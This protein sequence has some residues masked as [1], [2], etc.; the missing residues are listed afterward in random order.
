[1]TPHWPQPHI[2]CIPPNPQPPSPNP[3]KPNNPF[4]TEPHNH[5]TSP[6]PPPRTC[7]PSAHPNW[8][9]YDAGDS[10]PP[11]SAR[12]IVVTSVWG[13]SRPPL[14]S[15]AESVKAPWGGGGGG[16]GWLGGVALGWCGF[17]WV[18]F[19]VSQH[20]PA[21]KSSGSGPSTHTTSSQHPR[22]QQSFLPPAAL[23]SPTHPP[24]GE[25]VGLEL[26]VDCKRPLVAYPPTCYFRAH[27]TAPPAARRRCGV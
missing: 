7:S 18:R 16:A 1:M 26:A 5:Q 24:T 17:E 19:V 3:P 25:G 14:P 2:A 4:T 21:P 13:L 20:R 12:T 23:P 9:R 10:Q 15:S 27:R 8:K 6:T 11:K 22:S